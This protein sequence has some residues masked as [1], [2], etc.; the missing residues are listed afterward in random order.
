MNEDTGKIEQIIERYKDEGGSIVGLMQDIH[1]EYRYLPEEIIQR[2]AEELQVPL[3]K[4]Y[5][6]ATFYKSF[7]LEPVG[8]HYICVCMG[9]A[10]HVNGAPRLVDSLERELNIK[11]G[12]TT[13]D[14]KFTVETVNC[15]GTCALGPLVVID[16]EYYGKMD[17]NKLKKLLKKY[18]NK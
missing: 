5:S 2:V 8:K 16:G 3:S 17:Q 14:S 18:R 4:L 9:T 7:R 1:Q 15:L 11:T 6:L 12:Q 10:C 13:K